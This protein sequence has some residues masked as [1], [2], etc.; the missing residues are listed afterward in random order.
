MANE[1]GIVLGIDLGTTNSC[2]SIWY[3]GSAEIVV[4]ES[5]NR[6]TPSIVSFFKNQRLIGNA[7]VNM[8][9]RNPEN[10]IF[11]AKRFIGR[12]FQDSEVQKFLKNYPC[13]VIEDPVTKKPKFEVEYQNKKETFFPEEISS[14]I[15][16][17]IK[18]NAKNYLNI[19]I[20]DAII[21]VPA[22]FNDLQRKAT[23]FAGELAGLNVLRIINEPTA[24]AIAYGLNKGNVQGR[25][26]LIFDLGGGTFDVT[27]LSID[28][29]LL[30]VRSSRGDM[31]LGGND[32]D[33]ELLDYCIQEFKKRHNVE[34]K[35]K[36]KKQNLKQICENAKIN[37]SNSFQ[38]VIIE[39]SQEISIEI[40]RAEFEFTCK[41]HFDKLIPIVELALEDAKL[42]KERIN[43]I[44][45]VGG[46]TRIPK[47]Q[48]IIKNYFNK[49]PLRNINADEAVAIG[50]AIQGAIAN[51][52]ED[53]GLEKLILLDV[54][55]LSLGVKL[56]NGEMDVLIK[57]NTTIPCEVKRQFRG[58]GKNIN[59][60]IYQGERKLASENILLDK[61]IVKVNPNDTNNTIIEITFSIDINGILT[62]TANQINNNN[63]VNL[64]IHIE[65]VFDEESKNKMIKR[66]KELEEDDLKY[67]EAQNTRIQLNRLAIE[68]KNNK[69][70]EAKE[71]AEKILR[72]INANMDE[73]ISVYQEKIKELKD[74]I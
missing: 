4:N 18:N 67:I 15:L 66:A 28:G 35:D 53:V 27:I 42:T 21:T 45:L 39:P 9:K 44:V 16:S 51:I 57:R 55:P 65:N 74:L 17:Q 19:E 70:G 34:I 20:K 26:V 32:F 1:I 12:N 36:K 69:S 24:A 62:V 29:N 2:L 58:I 47:I 50:A 33:N 60:L 37:L 30:E 56:K 72:W 8:M 7:A 3:N 13:K 46:S 64:V 52:I 68:I 11:S 71:K 54:T 31:N 41:K 48:E 25:N 23:K 43:D 38:T 6:T 22:Y 14:F 63:V 40:T 73:K 49:E 10:T 59:V 5:G 61:C